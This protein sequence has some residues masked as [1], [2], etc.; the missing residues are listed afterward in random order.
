MK[1]SFRYLLILFI[2]FSSCENH[3]DD[4]YVLLISFD[5]FRA[6]YLDWFDTHSAIFVFKYSGEIELDFEVEELWE[7]YG[8]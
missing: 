1:F 5:G 7:I 2:V 8:R 3:Q 6:D 4:S